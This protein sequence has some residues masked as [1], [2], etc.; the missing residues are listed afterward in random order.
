M[1]SSSVAVIIP[2]SIGMIVYGTVTGTS[3]GQLFTAGFLPELSMDWHLWFTVIS[4]QN[5]ITYPP[6]QGFLSE[7][8]KSFKSAGW[9]LGIPILILGGISEDSS[10]PQNLPGI[11]AAYAIVVSCF[12]HRELI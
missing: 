1:A 5:A 7:I 10:H 11:V 6:A 8:W 4:M 12:I 9:A 3:I 2:P